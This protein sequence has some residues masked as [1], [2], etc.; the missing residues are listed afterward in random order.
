MF[1]KQNSAAMLVGPEGYSRD[2]FRGSALP[3]G[4]PVESF[5]PVC[6]KSPL[7][8]LFDGRGRSS[9]ASGFI[10]MALGLA[11]RTH[12]RTST[13]VAFDWVVCSSTQEFLD[14]RSCRALVVYFV[15]GHTRLPTALATPPFGMV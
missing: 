14:R 10:G 7:V 12:L 4:G 6:C 13:H 5:M 15:G 1:L 3:A 2:S 11:L 8:V 9:A